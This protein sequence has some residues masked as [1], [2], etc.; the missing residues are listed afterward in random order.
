VTTRDNVAIPFLFVTYAVAKKLTC[1]S[2]AKIFRLGL[3]GCS[4]SAKEQSSETMTTIVIVISISFVVT[5]AI[6][7]S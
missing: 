6:E 5:V 4:A 3:F 7:K 1:F 2:L